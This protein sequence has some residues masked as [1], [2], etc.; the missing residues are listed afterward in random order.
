MYF[1]CGQ[2]A[3]NNKVCTSFRDEMVG[4]VGNEAVVA[5]YAL[6]CPVNDRGCIPLEMFVALFSIQF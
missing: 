6:E 4:G 1:F 3:E 5:E 2:I